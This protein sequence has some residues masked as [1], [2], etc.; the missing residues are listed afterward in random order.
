MYARAVTLSQFLLQQERAIPGATGEF[1]SLLHDIQLSAKMINREVIRAGLTDVLGYTGA[2]NVHGER[3]QKLDLFAHQT[4]SRVLGSTGQ[5]AVMAS[6]EDEN[7][8]PVPK[9][10]PFGRYVV[11]F[12]PLDG[13][14][15]INAGVNIGTIFSVLPRVT[16]GGSGQLEDCLQPGIR[17]V[18]AGYVMYGSSTVLVYTTGHGVHGFT[19]EPDVGEFLL[20]FPDIRTPE[21]GRIYSV[22]EG[23]YARWSDPMKRYID[24]LKEEDESTGRPYSG[25]YV[26]SL[27]ADFHRNLLYGG[28]YL[29]PGDARSPLGKLRLLYEAAPLAFI[30]EQAGGAANDGRARI[31]EAT[32]HILHQR[33][34]LFIGSKKD[35]EDCVQFLQGK[36]PAL[37][38]DRRDARAA[39]RR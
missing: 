1:T 22:N 26:G 16:A 31:M 6:E 5:L 10:V 23:N 27:V 38:R 39:A 36:H 37:N 9:D 18:C 15:N 20:S 32:P 7:I 29:Y 30:A 28:L 25:R 12:D 14:S 34:P 35:V 19:F 17:Q 24:W 13:S 2:Q 4:I 11:N 21:H 3:V 8:I 33:T